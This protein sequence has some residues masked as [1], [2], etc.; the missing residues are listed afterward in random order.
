MNI[1]VVSV[2]AFSPIAEGSIS[3]GS[4]YEHIPALIPAESI[5]DAAENAKN[6]ALDKWKISEGWTGHQAAIISVTQGFYDA[7]LS[8]LEAGII[9]DADSVSEERTFQFSPNAQDIFNKGKIDSK[10][11]INH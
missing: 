11:K 4:Y 2:L 9:D 7:A 10:T 1:Y 3:V 6:F 5:E 8:A